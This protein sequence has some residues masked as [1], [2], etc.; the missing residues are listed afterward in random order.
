MTTS[1]RDFVE[2]LLASAVVFG[3]APSALAAMPAAHEPPAPGKWDLSWTDRVRGRYKVVVDSPEISE[4]AAVFRA[5]AWAKHY[6]DAMGTRPD[7]TATVLVLRH[8][9]IPLVMN[10]AFWAEYAVGEKDKVNDPVTNK[11]AVRNPVMLNSKEHGSPAMFDEFA[12]DRWGGNRGLGDAEFAGG[13]AQHGAKQPSTR[14]DHG[15]IGDRGPR[16]LLGN[17]WV[18]RASRCS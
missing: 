15:V 9:A 14:K 10:H 2:K 18:D 12:L 13:S 8:N 16:K 11:P 17:A 6:G 5:T 4:G 7:E 3:A 1:R